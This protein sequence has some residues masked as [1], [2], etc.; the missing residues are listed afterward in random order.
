MNFLTNWP[1]LKQKTT[2]QTVKR[3]NY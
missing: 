2:I 3:G 1:F